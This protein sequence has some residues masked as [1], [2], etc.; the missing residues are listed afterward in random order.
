MINDSA[1]ILIVDDE[2]KYIRLIV[3][4]LEKSEANYELM[5]CTSSL[6]AIEIAQ[7]VTP[8][9][10][11][12]DWEM[13]NLTGIEL[14]KKLKEKK[15]TSRIPVVM[16]T[17]AMTTPENLEEALSQGAFD[18]I[19]KPVEEVELIARVSSALKVAKKQNEELETLKEEILSIKT[20]FIERNLKLIESLKKLK[21]VAENTSKVEDKNEILK[22]AHTIQSE[23]KMANWAEFNNA[24][25]KLYPNFFG[26]L[27]GKFPRLSKNETKICAYIKMRMSTKEIADF[28]C[29]ETNS[30]RIARNRLR[31]KLELSREDNLKEFF[32]IL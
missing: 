2:V 31:K 5:R 23:S 14:I 21:E 1:K 7:E 18:Y 16:C 3:E 30:V 17:G 13:P 9:L 28:I 22:I 19:R 24:F 32:S 15:K 6:E 11:I 8:D 25:V 26:V 4:I 20:R 27:E 12:T 29:A 10:I